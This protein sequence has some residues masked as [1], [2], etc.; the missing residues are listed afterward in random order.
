MQSTWQ[1]HIDA[2]ISSTVNLPN[3]TPL[4]DVEDLYLYAWEKG[5]KGI[6]IYRAGCKREGIL[7]ADDTKDKT[8]VDDIST[9]T[10]TKSL[11]LK[12][13]DILNVYD[14][15]VG[16][17]R[18]LIS[19]C[20][21][22]HLETYFDEL[23][24]EPMETFI[25]IGSSGSCERNLQ[26]ISR[27]MSLCLRAGVPIECIIDQCKSI[28]P[29]PAYVSRSVKKGDTSKGGSCP[30]AIGFALEELCEKAKD[31]YLTD[32]SDEEYYAI[33]TMDD[34]TDL[35]K[36]IIEHDDQYYVDKGLCPNCHTP[37]KHEG[38]CMICECGWSKCD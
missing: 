10:N 26:L 19:G 1:Y 38:G 16:E 5:L 4:K 12:R 23:T 31:L 36:K 20:G 14:D 34:K 9:D 17:K 27:L 3:E 11:K 25:N 15:L 18:K 8:D 28:K 24:A 7:V 32:D 35:D 30:N 13:G 29:C 37:L 21:S 22:F 2:S 6:T 33:R